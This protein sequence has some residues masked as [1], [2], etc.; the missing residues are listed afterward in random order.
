MTCQ[1]DLLN[2]PNGEA[3]LRVVALTG[4]RKMPPL[5]YHKTAQ[6]IAVEIAKPIVPWANVFIS[7]NG[8]AAYFHTD[9]E[10]FGAV[11]A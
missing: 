9:E 4:P 3:L 11:G 8:A 5:M 10:K 2:A 1:R 7:F 6:L